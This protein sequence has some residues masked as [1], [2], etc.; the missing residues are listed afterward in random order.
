MDCDGA[1]NSIDSTT[2]GEIDP[3]LESR[4]PHPSWPTA[5]SRPRHLRIQEPG[6]PDP[7]LS[8]RNVF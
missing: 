6:E 3:F 1:N 5:I 2:G 7:S 4:R 8:F